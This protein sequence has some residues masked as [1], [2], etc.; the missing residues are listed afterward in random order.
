MSG[1][2]SYDPEEERR[3]LRLQATTLEPLGDRLL[4]RF[5]LAQKRALEVACGAMGLLGPLSRR[6]GP[7]GSVVG[8]D[9]SDLMLEEA[10]RFCRES[11]LENV[12]LVKDD[13]YNSEL[14]PPFDLVH[15]RFVLA[16]LGRDE[17]L[18]AELERLAGED[19]WIVLE[20]PSGASWRTFPESGAHDALIAVIKRAYDRHMGGFDAGER[21]Y[22]LARRRGWREIGVDAQLLALPPGHPYLAA[23]LMMA[24]SLRQVI[25][26]DT[27]E[28]E[29][30]ALVAAAHDLYARS[31]THGLTF[32]LIQLWAKGPSSRP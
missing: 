27:P 2:A 14:T 23:P 28:A 5:P 26:R 9:L 13:A 18:C 12:T 21:L 31:E 25:L 20:E 7:S 6:V 30:D 19:G 29:L 24:S 3:R 22:A 11:A 17:V 16:P 15:A 8:A 4:E 32:T 10:R 1:Y